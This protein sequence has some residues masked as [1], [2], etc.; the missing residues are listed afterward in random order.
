MNGIMCDLSVKLKCVFM[1]VT[2]SCGIQ[3]GVIMWKSIH[4]NIIGVNE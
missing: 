1:C 2:L 3:K 4:G